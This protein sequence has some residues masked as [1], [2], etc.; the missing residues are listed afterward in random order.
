VRGEDHHLTK[1][2]AAQV[3][4]IRQKRAKGATL[5]ALS[6]EYGVSMSGISGIARGKTWGHLG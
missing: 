3:R 5:S 4:A 6:L 1:V 2:T